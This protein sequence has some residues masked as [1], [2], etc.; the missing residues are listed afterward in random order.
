MRILVISNFFP[1]FH[2]G[3]YGVL[4]YRLCECLRQEG[5]EILVLTTL[6][7]QMTPDPGGYRI[8]VAVKRE[9]CFVSGI[10]AAQLLW[11]T[12]RNCRKVAQWM[13][14]FDPDL[15]YCFGIDGIGYQVYHT[16][17]ESGT[18]SIT[19]VGDTWLVQAWRDLARFDPW[20]GFVNSR[21]TAGIA[22]RVKRMAGWCGRLL[23]LYTGAAPLRGHPVHAI[24]TFLVDELKKAGYPWTSQSRLI[25]YPLMPPFVTPD[26]KAVGK[27][28]SSSPDLRVLFVSRMEM[29]KG[30]DVAVRAVAR[31]THAGVGVKLTLCGIGAENA[32]ATI[33]RLATGLRVAD[34]I[35]FQSALTPEELAG[36]YRAHDVFV[37]PSR[38]VEG[39]G[40]VCLEA[41]ACGLPVLATG[42]GGQLDLVRD[43]ITGLTFKKGDDAQLAALME[44]MAAD[45][46][47]RQ[48][49]SEQAMALA[50]SYCYT[51]VAGDIE[52]S[53]RNVA[54]TFSLQP[55]GSVAR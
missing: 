51:Q 22:R 21:N 41:M 16:A 33:K 10:N 7:R 12:W 34:R 48:R 2:A 11:R 3:G 55:S 27:D 52:K 30:P 25:K 49:M 47:L 40:I 24:S 14:T 39:L 20:I 32:V 50:E 46:V 15:V 54:A 43:G 26:N 1:P 35:K 28:G 5:H 31:A 23:G 13:K 4:C 29:L 8:M 18:A 37:F 6:P 42:E 9:L 45:S 19:V 44:R 38:I 17:V 53:V 36:L